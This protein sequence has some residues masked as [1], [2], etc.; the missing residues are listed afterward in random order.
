MI[1]YASSNC[2]AAAGIP[3]AVGPIPIP[4]GGI[5]ASQRVSRP[6]TMFGATS[7]PHH[8]DKIH[9]IPNSPWV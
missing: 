2:A 4:Y 1:L 5:H 8:V 6:V 7:P 9:P 3:P